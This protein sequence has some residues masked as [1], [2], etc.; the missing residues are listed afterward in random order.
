MKKRTIILALITW[1]VLGGFIP[2]YGTSTPPDWTDIGVIDG[3]TGTSEENYLIFPVPV[4]KN[5]TTKDIISP[6]PKVATLG[7]FGQIPVGHYT[8]TSTIDIPLYTVNYKD[9]YI[10]ISILYNTMGNKPDI[11]PGPVGLGWALQAGGVITRT[12]NGS[13]DTG[14]D[15]ALGQG[16]SV[17]GEDIRDRPDWYD[18]Y[19]HFG[20]TIQ[21]NDIGF[22]GKVDP[23]EFNYNING[24]T[25]SFYLTYQNKFLVRSDQ[26][27]FFNVTMHE[28]GNMLYH[29]FPNGEPPQMQNLTEEQQNKLFGNNWI[30]DN[31][32]NQNSHIDGVRTNNYINGFTMTD[33]KGI[34]Y[35]FGNIYNGSSNDNAI[36]FT[37]LGLKET[38]ISNYSPY[39]QAMAWYLTSIESPNGYK[40]QLEY[41]REYYVTKFRFTDVAIYK[42]LNG[43]TYLAENAR[44]EDAYR[45]VFIN[46]SV[47]KEII[48]PDGKVTFSNS[49]ATEQIDFDENCSSEPGSYNNI[50]HFNHFFIYPDISF[51]NTEKIHIQGHN[52]E[53]DYETVRNRF[54]PHKIDKIS[55]FNNKDNNNPLKTIDFTYTTSHSQRLK[56]QQ[57]VIA[58]NDTNDIAALKYKFEYNPKLLP[59]YLSNKTDYYGFY[60]NQELYSDIGDSAIKNYI[61]NNPN[62]YQTKKKPNFEYAEAEA[63]TKIIYPTGGYSQLEYEP[64]EFGKVYQTWQFG[65]RNITPTDNTAGDAGGLRVKSIKKYDNNNNMIASKEYKYKNKQDISSGVLA[66]LPQYTNAYLNVENTYSRSNTGSGGGGGSGGSGGGGG[67]G[68]GHGRPMHP[69]DPNELGIL[70][71]WE[72]PLLQNTN[73]ATETCSIYDVTQAQN[74]GFY[75]NASTAVRNSFDLFLRFS[76]NPT[77]PMGTTRGSHV[78]YSEVKVIDGNSN[79]INGYT[80]YKYKNYDNCYADLPLLGYVCNKLKD[81]NYGTT[82][83][84]WTNEEGMTMKQERGQLISE[85]LYDKNNNIIKKTIYIY[86]NDN[87]RF[88]ENVSFIKK[89]VNDISMSGSQNIMLLAGVIYTYHPW[90]K[91]KRET[92]YFESGDSL[93]TTTTHSYNEKYRLLKTTEIADSRGDVLKNSISYPFDNTEIAIYNE[94]TE[95]SMLE[96][97]IKYLSTKNDE[98]ILET[99]TEY[100]KGTAINNYNLIL[101]FKEYVKVGNNPEQLISTYNEYDKL[102]NPLSITDNQTGDKVCYLWSYNGSLPVAKI[103][104]FDYAEVEKM[105]GETKINDLWEN[106]NPGKSEIESIRT[107]ME[108]TGALITTYT[109][110]PLVGMISE[111]DFRGIT[112]Y[113]EY[114]KLGRLQEIKVG[115]KGSPDDSDE[116]KRK[117][118]E[119]YEY[120]YKE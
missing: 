45:S 43:G 12:I 109:Y 23:D 36:E 83:P 18:V 8:G 116:D 29:L 112:K 16:N 93:V 25:G 48:F 6:S 105:V 73:R 119:K 70:S 22:N 86:N 55:I 72:Q 80:I 100:T 26:G 65:V 38:N 103:I 34:K 84:F 107:Y 99:K 118:I 58:G 102:G 49:L 98:Q 35:T 120:H 10:P 24:Q 78:T 108:N 61:I 87:N 110:Q 32:T 31:Y 9:L 62:Y 28:R 21:L 54:F 60:T 106:K 59:P 7:T 39:I 115:K 68:H 85:E 40:I 91:Q 101:P 4:P 57:L 67:S 104:G 89:V 94:M 88:N 69:L 64:H 44:W 1:V 15:I 51:A 95:R 14:G 20:S 76:S 30:Y 82:F 2:D 79:E 3:I 111:T 41:D 66:Y 11:F 117:S 71:Q 75:E 63:L 50:N 56:L 52:T 37:R 53:G 5:G 13:P 113:Y 96:Y 17:Y 42:Y 92:L 33:S 114:D 27:E 19:T 81:R 97:P 77:H 46:G 90:L 74:N 47:L